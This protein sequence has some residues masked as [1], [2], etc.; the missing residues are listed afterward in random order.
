M[1]TEKQNKLLQQDLDR[2]RV[3][4]RSQS[5]MSLSYLEGYDVIDTANQIF[6]FDGWSYVVT[7]LEKVSETKNAKGNAVIAYIAQV[8]VSVNAGG[9]MVIKEDVGFGNGISKD[10]GGAYESA[11]KEAVTD[12]LKRALRSLGN[13]FGNALYDKQ[14]RQV[15]EFTASEIIEQA[16]DFK[17]K[18]I[19]T[20]DYRAAIV[21]TMQKL[22][23]TQD[24]I[25]ECAKLIIE[26]GLD[27]R[28]NPKDVYTNSLPQLEHTIKV[29]LEAEAVI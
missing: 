17:P 15:R 18:N 6:G 9:D 19:K 2:A 5:G 11:T 21:E 13:Q 12:A 24:K 1:F 27:I 4:S 3:A 26:D 14:Q 25:P 7:K 22:G 29:F 10:I 28:E 20:L 16:K 23:V 8:K